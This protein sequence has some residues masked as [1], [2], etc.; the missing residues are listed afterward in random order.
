M[1]I[2]DYIKATRP[3]LSIF[4]IEVVIGALIALEFNISQMDVKKL[5]FIF[6]SFQLLYFGIYII[7]DIIDYDY[8]KLSSR[9]KHRPIASGKISLKNAFIFF[10]V[11]IITAI[12]I[13][14]KISYLLLIFEII[15]LLYIIIYSLFL[16]K[17]PY[18]DTFSGSA[19]H[20]ARVIMGIVLFG[21]YSHYYLTIFMSIIFSSLLLIKRMK[22]IIY[23]ENP[24]RPIK[25]YSMK[26]IKTFWIISFFIIFILFLLG[27]NLE[28]T[29]IGIIGIIYIFSIILYLYNKKIKYLFEKIGD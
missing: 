15:F 25:Y 17:I 14:I 22:E 13:A 28:K 3:H 27:Q 8:D 9:K 21:T 29:I 23:S 19:T 4:F 20:T 11:L 10:L 16:K 26:G 1:K 2:L 6:I 18:L 5:F 12:L 7:N 24:K